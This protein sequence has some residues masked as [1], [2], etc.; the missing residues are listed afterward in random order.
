MKPLYQSFYSMGET[1]GICLVSRRGGKS[2]YRHAKPLDKLILVLR[3]CVL[4]GSLRVNYCQQ[5]R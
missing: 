3:H 4:K 1:L 2:F 5:V